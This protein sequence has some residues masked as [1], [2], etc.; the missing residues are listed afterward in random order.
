MSLA[1]QDHV[2]DQGV[3]GI[4]G[5]EGRDGS[6]VWDRMNRYGRWQ[7]LIGENISYGRESAREIVMGLIIDDGVPTRGHRKNIFNGE[8]GMMGV[9]YGYHAKYGSICVITFAGGYIE[10]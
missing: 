4:M 7:K 10:K 3:K 5:H 6:F 9:A 2:E 1:A 8:Y